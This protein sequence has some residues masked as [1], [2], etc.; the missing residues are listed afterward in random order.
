[1]SGKESSGSV[2]SGSFPP[3]LVHGR[4]AGPGTQEQPLALPIGRVCPDSRALQGGRPGWFPGPTPPGWAQ[5]LRGGAQPMTML[6][7]FPA[8]LL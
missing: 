1:M 8:L 3:Q 6:Y 5:V 2:P 7:H 4:E